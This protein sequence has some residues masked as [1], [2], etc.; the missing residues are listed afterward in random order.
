MDETDWMKHGIKSGVEEVWQPT[1]YGEEDI[2]ETDGQQQLAF[3]W[4]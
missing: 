3:V 1:E 4:K 2:V